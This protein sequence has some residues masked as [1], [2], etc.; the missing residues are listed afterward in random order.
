M[1]YIYSG[2]GCENSWNF[3]DAEKFTCQDFN[4]G[5]PTT[6]GEMSF[7]V[8]TDDDGSATYTREYVAVDSLYEMDAGGEEFAANS[9]ITIYKN[10]N[11]GDLSN[12]LQSVQFHSSCSQSLALKNRFGA[13]ILVEW[14]NEEQGTIS[15]FGNASFSITVNIPVEFTGGPATVTSLTVASNVDPFFFNLTDSVAGQTLNAGDTFIAEV[16]VPLD[17]SEKRTYTLLVTLQADTA[18]GTTCSATEV[19]SF[20]AGF[21]LPPIFPTFAPTDAPSVRRL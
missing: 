10:N 3:M 15:C 8:V 12:L 16:S 5:P 7:I 2:G 4:G 17:L 18:G 14:T 6:P 9:I 1:K 11:T 19:L 13:S 21:P 20:E